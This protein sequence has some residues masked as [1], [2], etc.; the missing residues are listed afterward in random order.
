MDELY[1]KDDKV[2]QADC[3]QIAIEWFN[4]R[5]EKK[6]DEELKL[7]TQELTQLDEGKSQ[8]ISPWNPKTS[9]AQTTPNFY[10]WA[11]L[12]SRFDYL[13]RSLMCS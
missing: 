10:S 2:M 4:Q 6:F 3:E 12:G 9:Q 13:V 11:W 1:V 7:L 8:S 5:D